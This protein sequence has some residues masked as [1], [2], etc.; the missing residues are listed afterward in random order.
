MQVPGAL[1]LK[2]LKKNLV[3]LWDQVKDMHKLMIHPGHR[4]Q[5][6]IQLHLSFLAD[7]ILVTGKIIDGELIGKDTQTTLSGTYVIPCKSASYNL[8]TDYCYKPENL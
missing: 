5:S 4:N 7:T 6:P 1:P 8:I 2:E 3:S